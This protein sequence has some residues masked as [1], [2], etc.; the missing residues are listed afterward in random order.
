M[1][2]WG[3]SFFL[4]DCFQD[5]RLFMSQIQEKLNFILHPNKASLP[6]NLKVD[7]I[8]VHRQSLDITSSLCQNNG[9]ISSKAKEVLHSSGKVGINSRKIKTASELSF[10][11]L[12]NRLRLC[13]SWRQARFLRVADASRCNTH[14]SFHLVP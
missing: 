8:R 2:H 3:M 4:L 7:A 14:Y 5:L 6:E 11:S 10:S 9:F 13:I 12:S 1:L